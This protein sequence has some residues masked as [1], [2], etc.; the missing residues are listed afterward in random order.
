M[1][2]GQEMEEQFA[3]LLETLKNQQMNEFR[4]LFLALD[5]SSAA[6]DVYK[7]QC[8]MLSKKIMRI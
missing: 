7:R 2:E 6:S 8:L 1:N 3:L 5:R 4:E